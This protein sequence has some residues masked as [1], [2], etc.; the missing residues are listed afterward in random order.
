MW[1]SNPHL[2][3]LPPHLT[4]KLNQLELKAKFPYEEAVIT[5]FQNIDGVP[6]PLGRGKIV[7]GEV[8]LSLVTAPRPGVEMQ[9]VANVENGVSVPLKPAN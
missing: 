9:F 7:N 6:L 8:A 5:V 2:I 3:V 4:V 1:T